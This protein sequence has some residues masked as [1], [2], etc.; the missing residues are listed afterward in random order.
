MRS[1]HIAGITVR[2]RGGIVPIRVDG[3]N[4]GSSG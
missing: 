1:K 4:F 3:E 2:E